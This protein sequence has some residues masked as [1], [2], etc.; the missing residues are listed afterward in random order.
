MPKNK[1]SLQETHPQVADQ[2]HPDKNGGLTPDQIVA[3]S[4][5]KAWW[6]CGESPDHEWNA[7]I[8]SRTQRDGVGCPFCAGKKVSITN[9][10]AILFPEVANQ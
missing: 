10:L 6:K 3:G 2:W 9:G 5:K 1:L 7:V 8:N 4:H